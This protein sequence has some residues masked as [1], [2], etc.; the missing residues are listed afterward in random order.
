MR[1][2]PKDPPGR[3]NRKARAFELEIAKLRADGY[4]CG[5]IRKALADIGVAVSLS[6]VQR[7]AARAAS[8]ARSAVLT[9]ETSQA[10]TA[11]APFPTPTRAHL[12]L[13]GDPRTGKEIAA[14]FVASRITNPLLRDRSEHEGRGH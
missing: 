3:V 1:L 11:P 8:K 9:R 14:A 10:S 12:G 6:T 7:E 13:V 2:I 4:T 5:A